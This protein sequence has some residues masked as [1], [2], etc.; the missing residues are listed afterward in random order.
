MTP[1]ALNGKKASRSS[2]QAYKQIKASFGEFSL[3]T[4]TASTGALASNT[5][6]DTVY[7]DTENELQQLGADRDAL[8]DQIRLALWNAEFNGQKL[9]EKQAKDWIDQ[10][11]DLLDRAA[12]ARGEVQVRVRARRSSRRSSTSS[13]STRRT[14]ASTTCTAAGRA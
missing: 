13:S 4:L 5:S 7:T 9:D 6:G 8:A 11:N 1:K 10:A 12:R 14:T 3:D 2:A